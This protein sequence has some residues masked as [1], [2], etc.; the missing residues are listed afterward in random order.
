[1]HNPKQSLFFDFHTQPALPDVGAGFDVEH[2]TD[3]I[4]A[5][6]A[7][8]IV[9]PAKC[10]M[11]MAYYETHAGIRHPSLTYDLF[12]RLVESCKQKDIAISAYIN[13]GLSHEQALRH[14]DWALVWP[15]GYVHRPNPLDH[16]F[17]YMC[18]DTPYGDWILEIVREV[19]S[20][21]PVDGLFLDCFGVYPCVG[22]ECV[23]GM[24]DRGWNPL[25]P[26][27]QR[28]H[29]HE[30]ELRMARRIVET[31][32]S[33]RPDLLFFFNGIPPEAQQ[34]FC[35]HF[36]FECLPTGGWGYDLLPL[37]ARYLRTLGKPVLNMTGRFHRSWGDFG[38]LRTQASLDY[39]LLNGL[40][41]GM[42]PMVG[43]HMHPRGDA[44]DAVFDLIEN[45]YQRTSELMPWTDAAEAVADVGVIIPSHGLGYVDI[46]RYEQGQ[47]LL[48]GA[49][50]MLGELNVQFDVLSYQRPWDGYS[51]LV[52][53]D[54]IT[55]DAEAKTK[56]RAHL[57]RGGAILATGWSGLNPERQ[58][59]VFPEWGVRFESDDPFDPAFY[60]VG[61][62]LA[63]GI[64]ALRH[65]FYSTGVH[66]TAQPGTDVLAHIVAPYFNRH[67]DGEH[68]FLYL[69]PDRITDRPAVTLRGRVGY[70]SH[71]VFTGYHDNAPVPLRQMVGNLLRML[72]PDPQVRA[73]D[74]PS[75]T[76]VTVMQQTGRRMVHVLSY[77]PE[78]RGPS[79][80]MIEEPIDLCN[81]SIAL[82]KD[83]QT[84]K[85]VYLA[86]SQEVLPVEE[87]D[88]YLHVTIPKVPG[89]AL[90]VF[91]N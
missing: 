34:D 55:L 14:R 47:A 1:M 5:C 29:A 28:M 89:H 31:A 46:Q 15:E 25:D 77:V 60:Q 71:A 36:E 22:V 44:D 90:V 87:S 2:F 13:V 32:R 16:F 81:V 67:W 20:G 37:Y 52:L 70:I 42:R 74:L 83:G 51:V 12:G 8:Y 41:N 26:R 24:K 7:N 43:G 53:P 9:F 38:G 68:H 65:N 6:K 30:R 35:T 23:Q 59:F 76:R 49:A 50:R 4:R 72:L 27:A 78:R 66:V 33:I 3:R 57:D 58:G 69:P 73:P 56:L 63:E 54:Q 40:A 86:P 79:M 75:F 91:E 11:G 64:P 61:P 19:V 84:P 48:K 39:D 88:G 21:Y 62:R 80:D 17:R 82:R 10:N 18:Y 45:A 85:K